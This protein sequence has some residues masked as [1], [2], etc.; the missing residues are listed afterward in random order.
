MLLVRIVPILLQIKCL[1]VLVLKYGGDWV[2]TIEMMM[3]NAS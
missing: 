3:I 1:E 2:G